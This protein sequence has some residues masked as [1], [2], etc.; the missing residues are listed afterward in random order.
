MIKKR[1][2]FPQEREKGFSLYSLF[3]HQEVLEGIEVLGH[4]DALLLALHEF[5][6][7]GWNLDVALQ[8]AVY[9]LLELGWMSS[10]QEDAN[11][12]WLQLFL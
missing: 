3:V 7:T 5:C 4:L 6:K 8:D 10:L 9:L 2:A 1:K 12:A 11:L